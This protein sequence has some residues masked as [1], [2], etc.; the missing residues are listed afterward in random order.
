M[1]P[2][3]LSLT[4]DWKNRRVVSDLR[5]HECHCD[6]ILMDSWNTVHVPEAMARETSKEVS[7]RTPLPCIQAPNKVHHQSTYLDKNDHNI[8]I[9]Q[10]GLK[11]CKTKP[12][13]G[14]IVSQKNNRGDIVKLQEVTKLHTG[15]QS[16]V[17]IL[18]KY[19]KSASFVDESSNDIVLSHSTTT[20]GQDAKKS[21][22]YSYCLEY[23]HINP[24]P[25]PNSTPHIQSPPR[26]HK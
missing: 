21:R 7:K 23:P 9:H 3:V 24:T 4:D 25:R 18:R 5:R 11:W 22:D 13:G 20:R 26:H 10:A 19:F 6:G 2:L 17:E 12:F 14:C 8:S 1:F 15:G 16:K